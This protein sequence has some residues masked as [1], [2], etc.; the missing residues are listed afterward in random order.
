MK[1]LSLLIILNLVQVDCDIL[2]KSSKP[3]IESLK[4]NIKK[5]PPAKTST[6][7]SILVIILP[8]YL[9]FSEYKNNIEISFIY[10]FFGLKNKKFNEIS[11]G[12][13]QMQLRFIDKYLKICNKNNF[14]DSSLIEYNTTDYKI[15]IDK[16]EELNKIEFQWEILKTFCEYNLKHLP[17]NLSDLN[18]LNSLIRIYNSGSVGSQNN[19]GIYTKINCNDLTYEEWCFEMANW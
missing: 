13:F 3:K 12:P 4:G 7:D 5:L 8:E 1:V 11:F 9:T 15:L 18:K 10:T 2:R 6:N 14:H 17:K 19:K 16:L